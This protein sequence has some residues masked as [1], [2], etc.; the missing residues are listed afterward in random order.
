MRHQQ[1][2]PTPTRST[3]AGTHVAGTAAGFG[4]LAAGR[5]FTGQYDANTIASHSWNVLGA[6]TGQC[7]AILHARLDAEAFHAGAGAAAW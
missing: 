5:R 4:V 2:T 6:A 1:H 3:A 7:R